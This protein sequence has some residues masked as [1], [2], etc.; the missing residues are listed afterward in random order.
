MKWVG[1]THTMR[2]HAHYHTGGLGHIYQQRF[3]S[4]PI[5][6]DEHFLVV[7]RYV[8]R[9]AKRA[10]LVDQVEKW[11]WGS[12]WRWTQNPEPRANLLSPWP[13][14]RL[15]N[16]MQRVN[17]LLS[18]KELEAVRRCAHRGQPFGNE[19]WTESIARR[20]NLEPT[21]RPHGRPKK[22]KKITSKTKKDTCPLF[23]PSTIE[24]HRPVSLSKYGNH[25]KN[26]YD[27]FLATAS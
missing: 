8:E 5:Q 16:W 25:R 6:N 17:E 22:L 7:R 21:L 3:K 27:H 14:P 9:N 24:Q 20:L 1:G 2:Y 11:Q 19:S 4:F 15:P 13:I 18:D 12:L 26:Y 10:G 23:H